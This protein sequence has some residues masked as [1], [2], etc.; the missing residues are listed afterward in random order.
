MQYLI[1]SALPE[2]E[3]LKIKLRT[4]HAA[5]QPQMHSSHRPADAIQL[6]TSNLP[7]I[8]WGDVGRTS[9]APAPSS[10]SSSSTADSMVWPPAS[11]SSSLT[12]NSPL[13]SAAT[14]YQPSYLPTS[15][16]ALQRH[17]LFAAKPTSRT[18]Q[19]S[20]SQRTR[21]PEV[22]KTPLAPIDLLWEKAA[23]SNGSTTAAPDQVSMSALSIMDTPGY[24]APSA[25]PSLGPQEC[26]VGN[27]CVVAA[28]KEY[29][30]TVSS[31]ISSYQQGARQQ[32]QDLLTACS[33]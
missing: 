8:D 30:N 27:V 9:S 20:T 28:H 25:G 22:D 1:D 19:Q 3:Q 7:E 5:V 31:C 11:R 4:K 18:V 17:A 14:D 2:L 24:P 13:A 16:H 10:S 6:V 15:Q 32:G 26:E 33:T 12:R 23:S 29:S 21:Y